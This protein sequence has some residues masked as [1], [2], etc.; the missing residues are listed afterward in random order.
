MIGN[1]VFFVKFNFRGAIDGN[2]GEVSHFTEGGRKRGRNGARLM[3]NS[4][5]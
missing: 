1:C 4:V 5:S 2:V 3:T